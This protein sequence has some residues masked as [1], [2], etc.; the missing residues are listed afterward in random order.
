MLFRSEQRARNWTNE[1]IAAHVGFGSSRRLY[2]AL[3]NSD[4]VTPG[5][6][7]KQQRSA[8]EDAE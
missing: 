2:R 8:L 7:R 5:Q 3:Q 6:Y 1:E 4:G